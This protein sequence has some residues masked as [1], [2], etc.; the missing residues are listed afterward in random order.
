MTNLYQQN[1]RKIKII[2]VI[3][4]I[5]N[6]Q[7]TYHIHSYQPPS[8]LKDKQDKTMYWDIGSFPLLAYVHIFSCLLFY[9]G[10]HFYC[11]FCKPTPWVDSLSNNVSPCIL[12]VHVYNY[13]DLLL[14]VVRF[15]LNKICLTRTKAHEFKTLFTV[16]SH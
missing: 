10:S 2:H 7:Y 8:H 12:S 6:M 13:I 16:G 11:K 15:F 14:R 9:R 5:I 1:D 4:W 3:A